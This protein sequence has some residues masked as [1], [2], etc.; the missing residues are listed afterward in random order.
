MTTQALHDFEHAIVEVTPETAGAWLNSQFDGQ[1]AMR[2][3]H[4]LLLAQEMEMG[5]SSRT[6]QSFSRSLMAATT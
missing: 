4:V 3:H 1:R 6:A 2:D 5:R